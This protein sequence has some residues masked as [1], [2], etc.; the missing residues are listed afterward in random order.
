MLEGFG[1]CILALAFLFD[2]RDE[3]Y[4]SFDG[5]IAVSVD[6][7]AGMDIIT[8]ASRSFHVFTAV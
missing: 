3:I 7:L 1:L 4:Y 5:I 8:G 6:N 2:T